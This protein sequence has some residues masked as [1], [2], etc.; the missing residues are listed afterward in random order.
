MGPRGGPTHSGSIRDQRLLDALEKI[1][2]RPYRGTVWRSV[3]QGADPLA[4][5]R[6]GGR[7]DDGSFDV[8]YTSETREAAIAERRFHLYQGQPIPPS[9]VRYELFELRVALEAVMLF[10]G[11][12]ALGALGLE[13]ARYGQLAYVERVQEYPRSQQ[14]AEACSFIGA[15]GILA[16]SAREL[17][18]NNL[19]VFCEQDTA[20]EMAIVRAHGAI[21]FGRP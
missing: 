6:S 11:L 2:Q 16:P 10:D 14:I 17:R 12:D 3:R 13:I 1:H 4:C 9:K 19:I 8:L 20:I 5:W 21:D 18:S 7:W 15:D